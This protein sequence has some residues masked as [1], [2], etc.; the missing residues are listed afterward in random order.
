M[1]N[2]TQQEI[3]EII[4]LNRRVRMAQIELEKRSMEIQESCNV[5]PNMTRLDIK[6]GQWKTDDVERNSPTPA[7][8]AKLA[9]RKRR[10]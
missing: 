10:D 1:R 3:S 4:A 5:G 2:A 6:T 9:K 7:F 8:A